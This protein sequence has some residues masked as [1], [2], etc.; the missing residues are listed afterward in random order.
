MQGEEES[1]SRLPA[2]AFERK[3][4]HQSEHSIG[5]R[6]ILQGMNLNMLLLKCRGPWPTNYCVCGSGAYGRKFELQLWSL[7][8]VRI[9]VVVKAVGMG[10]VTAVTQEEFAD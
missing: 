10:T 8:A 5:G 3:R 2:Q 7:I 4:F 6:D 9:D 1:N